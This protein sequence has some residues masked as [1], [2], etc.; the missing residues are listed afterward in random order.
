[1]ASES[2]KFIKLMIQETEE[3]VDFTDFL[4]EVL[5]FEEGEKEAVNKGPYENGASFRQRIRE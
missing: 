1:M 5:N 4:D 2:K 3:T